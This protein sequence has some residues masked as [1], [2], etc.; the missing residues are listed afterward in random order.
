MK[1]HTKLGLGAAAL[2]AAAI[3]GAALLDTAEAPATEP[4]SDTCEVAQAHGSP[5]AWAA[6]GVEPPPTGY[7][8]IESCAVVPDGGVPF[9]VERAAGLAITGTKPKKEPR[10]NHEKKARAWGKGA[11]F[12]CACRAVADVAGACKADL[13]EG[14]QAAPFGRYLPAGSWSGPC[15]RQACDFVA[16]ADGTPDEC[17][18]SVA[19]APP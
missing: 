1:A 13:G 8:M 11:P 16:G 9:A 3:A 6:I 4:L 15:V 5:E 17:R 14:T 12:D 18:P 2:A 19:E 7:G 10:G